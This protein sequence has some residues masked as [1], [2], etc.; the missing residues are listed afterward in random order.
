MPTLKRITKAE[1]KFLSLCPR[2]A[3]RMPVV[4]KDDDHF[5][6]ET[7]VKVSEDAG[8]ILAVVYAPNLVDA[9]GEFAD[10]DVIKQMAYGFARDRGNVD[11]RHDNVA[12]KPSQA[13]VAESFIV[14]KGDERFADFKDANG[15]AVDV[16]GA[17][18]TVVKV[19]DP[20]LRAKYRTGAWQGISMGGRAARA[21]VAKADESRL[22]KLV[23]IIKE[24]VAPTKAAAQETPM[25][26]DELKKAIES[27]L[28]ARGVKAPEAP[29]TPTPADDAPSFVGDVTKAEDIA[30]F[31]AAVAQHEIKKGLA[32]KDPAVRTRAIEAAKKLAAPVAKADGAS[33]DPK[34]AEIARLEKEL[35]AAK[36]APTTGTPAA[37]V[38]KEQKDYDE[39]VAAGNR[40]ASLASQSR[41]LAPSAK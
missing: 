12:V 35:A 30:S 37:V 2:G 24:L 29:A 4:Y 9:Q 16:T 10:A 26:A 13:Y 32:S 7:L 21:E 27:V 1:I 38:S 14:A 22:E 20:E 19:D 17:W 31:E 5:D 33:A 6:L 8:E 23:K 39:L 11:I 34:A 28:D 36:G 15:K 41:G 25:T 3:N 40:L 18:A